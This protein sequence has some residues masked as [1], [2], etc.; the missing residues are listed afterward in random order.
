M[1]APMP[2]GGGPPQPPPN[3]G[4]PE[5]QGGPP[6]PEK[7]ALLASPLSDRL[8]GAVQQ[9]NSQF[10][11]LVQK[12][13]MGLTAVS[14]VLRDTDPIAASK[15]EKMGADLLKLSA[16]TSV[17]P[18]AMMKLAQTSNLPRSGQQGPPPSPGGM[19]GVSPMSGIMRR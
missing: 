14:T 4:S 15:I 9:A 7:N 16:T 8:S 1:S 18:Q 11:Q 19:T 2:P 13:R 12:V 10:A 17:S 3:I 5:M 6:G